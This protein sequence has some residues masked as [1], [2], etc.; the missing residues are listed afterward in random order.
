MALHDEPEP[1]GMFLIGWEISFLV[2][3]MVVPGEVQV[4]N[5]NLWHRT[6]G[7]D[8]RY[9]LDSDTAHVVSISILSLH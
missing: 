9:V 7:N 3:H 6:T 4:T 8:R 1:Q 2:I 5:Y